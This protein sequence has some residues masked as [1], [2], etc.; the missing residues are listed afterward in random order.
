MTK[1]ELIK[2]LQEDIPLEE[3]INYRGEL[4]SAI[5]K[6]IKESNDQK[7]IV[8]LRLELYNEL[9]K[10][11]DMINELQKNKDLPIPQRVGLKVKEIANTINL[12]KEKNDTTTK[13]KGAVKGTTISS[14]FAGAIT[15]GLAALGEAPLTLATLAT[16]IPVVCYCG[17]SSLVRMPF[18]QTNWTKMVKNLDAS[19]EYKNKIISFMEEKVKNNQKLLELIKK[20]MNKPSEEEL[21]K[22]NNEM[23]E[24]YQ[25]LIN[26][27]P[28]DELRRILTFEKINILNEQKKI[29]ENIKKEYIKSKRDLTLPEFAELERKLVATDISI[30]ADN[31]FLKDV[32]KQGGKDFTISAGTIVAARSILSNFFPGYAISDLASLSVPVIFSLL[33]SISNMGNV[34]K[35]I[36]LEKEDYNKLKN[37]INP[38]QLKEKYGLDNNASLSMA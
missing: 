18:T 5:K 3:Q 14:L 38:E 12:F 11:K 8:T 24:K 7:E 10:H 2:K 35:K 23:I 37:N 36:E 20:K 30:A 31:T 32:L 13:L 21:L 28:V 1:E 4:I 26:T 6:E 22:I 29:Y 25:Q 16:A 19:P 17:L 9:K 27:A 34:K 15:V 33:G